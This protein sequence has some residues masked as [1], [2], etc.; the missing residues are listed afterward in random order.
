MAKNLCS[1]A[2]VNLERCYKLLRYPYLLQETNCS[3]YKKTYSM[4]AYIHF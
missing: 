3:L 1:M 2:A 4:L